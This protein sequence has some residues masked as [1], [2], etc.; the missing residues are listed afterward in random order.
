MKRVLVTVVSLLGVGG[1]ARGAAFTAG[2]LVVYRVGAGVGSLLSSATAVFL[3]EYSAAGTRVQSIPLPVAVS[4]GQRRLTASGTATSEGALQRS[5]DRR[6]LTVTGYDAD[7]GTAGVGA[8]A[9]GTVAR[10][11]GFVGQNGLVDT[12]TATTAFS[13]NNIRSAVSADGTGTW[14]CGGSHGVV[15]VARGSSGPGTRVSAT[16]AL[17]GAESNRCVEIASDQLL[18]S[19]ASGTT[20]VGQVG[21]VG[22]GGGL[23]Q[24]PGQEVAPL[25]AAESGVAVPGQFVLLEVDASEPGLD[26]LYVADEAATG[27]IHKFCLQAGGWQA[28]GKVPGSGEVTGLRGLAGSVTG[29]VVTLYATT[30]I[31]LVSLTDSAGFGGTLTGSFVVR[32][33]A[34]PNVGFRGIDFAPVAGA[35]PSSPAPVLTISQTGSEVVVAWPTAGAA[36]WF[37]QQNPALSTGPWMASTGVTDDGTMKRLTIPSAIGRQFFRLAL[38]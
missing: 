14:V 37:L 5:A 2:N 15:Y 11:V 7:V 27:G 4:G 25:V 20:R 29:G 18:V 23:P 6:F 8:T 22:G 17:S 19:T 21:G 26:T 31:R 33:S 34:G 36:G 28:R 1:T 10:V 35:P 16:A 13:A 24:E 12:A 38:P 9:S 32:A 3:D 30:S